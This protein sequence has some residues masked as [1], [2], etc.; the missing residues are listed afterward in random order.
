MLFQIFKSQKKAKWYDFKFWHWKGAPY[1]LA[2][3][4]TAAFWGP[5]LKNAI[6]RE[7]SEQEQYERDILIRKT[8]ERHG[9]RWWAFLIPY[10]S[11]WRELQKQDYFV[12]RDRQR[13]E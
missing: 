6:T 9:D 7:P 12:E 13:E 4:G 10:R 1:A 2:V 5:I 8:F 3:L 11:R